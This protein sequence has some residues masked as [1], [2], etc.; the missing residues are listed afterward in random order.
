[1][2][3]EIQRKSTLNSKISQELSD[4]SLKLKLQEQGTASYAQVEQEVQEKISAS[5]KMPLP[6]SAIPFDVA[7]EKVRQEEVTQKRQQQKQL[8]SRVNI[9]NLFWI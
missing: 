7:Q 3:E 2:E 8:L 9:E 1:M 6:T 5:E 4:W